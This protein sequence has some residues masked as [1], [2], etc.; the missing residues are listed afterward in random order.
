MRISLSSHVAA[1]AFAALSIAAPA[2]AQDPPLNRTRVELAVGEDVKVTT[3]DGKLRKGRLLRA[4]PAEIA[5][6][7]D[8]GRHA[9]A[10]SDILQIER[11]SRSI[12]V[13]ESTLI[14]LGVGLAVGAVSLAADGCEEDAGTIALGCAGLFA[15][16]GAGAGALTGVLVNAS[17]PTWLVFRADGRELTL[18][19]VVSAKVAGVSGTVRWQ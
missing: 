5:V 14:G 4:T 13:R 3:R 19:P 18:S 9:I 8:S 15:G 11:L 16:I 7:N 17:R 12:S 10:M 2:L 1:L 6:L